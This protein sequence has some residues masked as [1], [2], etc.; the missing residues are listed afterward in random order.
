MSPTDFLPCYKKLVA[1]FGQPKGFVNE[2]EKRY[3]YLPK[4]SEH[5]KEMFDSVGKHISQENFFLIIERYTEMSAADNYLPRFPSVAALMLLAKPYQKADHKPQEKPPEQCERERFERDLMSATSKL[6]S[7]P[8]KRRDILKDF[9]SQ[10]AEAATD[11]APF[12]KTIPEVMR[13]LWNAELVRWHR[14]NGAS[15]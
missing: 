8:S 11:A 7:L 4:I 2:D 13:A 12:L 3:P 15:S 14:Q 1:R 5:M 10:K 6:N 9:L